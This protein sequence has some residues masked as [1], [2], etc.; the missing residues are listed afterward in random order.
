MPKEHLLYVA[1]DH[2]DRGGNLALADQLIEVDGRF[3]FKINADHYSIFGLPYVREIQSYGKPVFVDLK[4][5]NGPRTMTNTLA[6]LA[7]VGV[8]HTNIWA[9]ADRLITPTVEALRNI[10][11]SQLVVLGVTVTSRFDDNYCQRHFGRSLE[12]SVRHFTN[13]AI[14]AGC[15]GVILP[16]T[17]LDII[18][19][20]KTVKLVSGI[21]PLTSRG[22]SIQQRQVITPQEAVTKGADI[23]VCGSPI[24]RSNDPVG[25]LT[26]ILSQMKESF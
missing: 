2:D 26:S 13:V 7:E 5:N 21:R 18:K 23:L 17:T 15:D 14:E 24:Y 20:I 8:N 19:D 1:L 25:V 6:P 16:G 22:D 3:G 12:M 10:E 9:L 4:I 11:K